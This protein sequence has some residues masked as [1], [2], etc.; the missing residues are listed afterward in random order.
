MLAIFDCS[1]ITNNSCGNRFSNARLFPIDAVSIEDDGNPVVGTWRHGNIRSKVFSFSQ[2]FTT[3]TVTQEMPIVIR[4]YRRN[5]G[6]KHAGNNNLSLIIPGNQ[7]AEYYDTTG[8]RI[9]SSI[10]PT[11]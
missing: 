2:T 9:K 7:A 1:G 10:A 3:P 6:D 8:R 5:I 11:P 4:F